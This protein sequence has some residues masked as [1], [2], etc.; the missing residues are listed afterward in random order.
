MG[1]YEFLED[2]SNDVNLHCSLSSMFS[3]GGGEYEVRLWYSPQGW[4]APRGVE[5]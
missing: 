3:F 1:S 5:Q 4:G 2:A